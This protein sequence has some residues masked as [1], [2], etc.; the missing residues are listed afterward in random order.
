MGK[1]AVTVT[2]DEA[3]LSDLEVAQRGRSRSMVVEEA[4]KQWLAAE[5]RRSIVAI[6]RQLYA[7][8]NGPTEQEKELSLLGEEALD[9]QP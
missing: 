6:Y 9:Q 2:I 8:E 7:G 5:R 3:L 1:R 4:L